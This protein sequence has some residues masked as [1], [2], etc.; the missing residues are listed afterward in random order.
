MVAVIG[1]SAV[2]ATSTQP[3]GEYEGRTIRFDVSGEAPRAWDI[4]YTTND[5]LVLLTDV[6]LPWSTSFTAGSRLQFDM[7][8]RGTG[9]MFCRIT[10]DGVEVDSMNGLV[11]GSCSAMTPVH[12]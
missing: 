11:D 1:A 9:A 3:K 6:P 7:S 4:E 5:D 10:V 12:K 2:I 8:A